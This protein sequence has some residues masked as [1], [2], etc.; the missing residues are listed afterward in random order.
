MKKRQKIL[1]ILLL[2]MLCV[3]TACTDKDTVE[4][5]DKNDLTQEDWGSFTPDITYS[6]DNKYYAV[7]EV[8]KGEPFDMIKVS[9]YL[10][11]TKEYVSEFYPARAWDFWGIC[12]EDDTYNIWIQSADIGIHCYKYKDGNWILD[13]DAVQPDSIVSRFDES[14]EPLE[15]V[16]A[17]GTVPEEEKT[18]LTAEVNSINRQLELFAAQTNIWAPEVEYANELYKFT[19]T[20][21][22]YDGK[23]DLIVSNFGGTGFYTYS[24]FY[25]I[26][27]HGQVTE[28]ETDFVEGDS[29]PDLIEDEMTV[30]YASSPEGV[31]QYFITGDYLKVSPREYYADIRALSMVDDRLTQ[32]VLARS[33]EIYEGEEP[34]ANITWLDADGN[35]ITE[36]K[37]H[38]AAA[39]Y[40]EPLGYE[41]KTATFSW[42][43]VSALQGLTEEEIVQLLKESYE[44]FSIK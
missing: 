37:Y 43:D 27:E 5:N 4:K 11:E 35:E 44:G 32:M 1:D 14:G 20:E 3:V 15:E 6:Y 26:D 10:T 28:M 24:H 38:S 19:V 31:S 40:F 9:I 12:W 41:K 2:L 16:P 21:L 8:E 7:Q 42:K 25:E 36:E 18:E 39:D 23:L 17:E 13:Y 34:Q 22:D 29:Q 33:S 30:Y